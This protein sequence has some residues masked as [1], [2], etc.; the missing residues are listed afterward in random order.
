MFD[1][2]VKTVGKKRG[3]KRKGEEYDTFQ[4]F[5]QIECLF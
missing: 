1:F 4:A 3:I 5:A 2:W